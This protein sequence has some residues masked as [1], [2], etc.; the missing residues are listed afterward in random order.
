MPERFEAGTQNSPGLAALAAGAE[1]VR[2]AGPETV[3]AKAERQAAFIIGELQ[4]E[5]NIR[6]YHSRPSLPIVSFNIRGLAERRRGVH[7][8]PGLRHRRPDGA[9]LR[10]PGAPGD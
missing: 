2:R 10:P 7:P 5:P 8:G 3:A 4:Q 1:F 6:V 9:P